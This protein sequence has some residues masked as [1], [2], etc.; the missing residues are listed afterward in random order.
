MA[1]VIG[2][3]PADLCRRAGW[4]RV[5]ASTNSSAAA[6][7]S[8]EFLAVHTAEINVPSTDS[9]GEPIQY[10]GMH[11]LVLCSFMLR[12]APP[13][14]G[15]MGHGLCSAS[16][17]V[18]RG[19]GGRQLHL[20]NRRL[21]CQ[22]MYAYARSPVATTLAQACAYTLAQARLQTQPTA[23]PQCFPRAPNPPASIAIANVELALRRGLPL[24][25]QPGTRTHLSSLD[26]PSWP[27]P[28][29]SLTIVRT[30]TLPSPYTHRV[31]PCLG[32]RNVVCVDCWLRS[33]CGEGNRPAAPM[34]RG[35]SCVCEQ[36]GHHSRHTLCACV[37]QLLL[38]P[39][40]ALFVPHSSALTV[41]QCSRSL[42]PCRC[43][44]LSLTA[45]HRSASLS[46]ALQTRE[47]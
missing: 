16:E 24:G 2:R 46:F 40:R 47:W 8:I 41:R 32:R 27:R 1:N 15:P 3:L 26:G 19:Q 45:H 25:T 18:L 6:G 7:A 5:T 13:D 39:F 35:L 12:G 21:C 30:V 20:Q 9:D 42:A 33:K 37:Q 36:V 22:A 29:A 44:C 23:R 4:L 38:A 10:D 28:P 34:H 43:I 11:A 17:G 31:C 14:V